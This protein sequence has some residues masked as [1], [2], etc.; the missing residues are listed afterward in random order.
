MAGATPAS[1]NQRYAR[2]RRGWNGSL[3]L[4]LSLSAG[5]LRADSETIYAEVTDELAFPL[6]AVRAVLL[7]LDR[8]DQW[9]PT[10]AEWRV[11]TRRHD[12]ARVYGRHRVP[13]PYRD[14]DY[15]VDY[16]WQTMAAGGFLLE[17]TARANCPASADSPAVEDGVVRIQMLQS[18]WTLVPAGEH[19][20][21]R[22]EI[23][24]LPPTRSPRWLEAAAQR[25]AGARLMRALQREVA[26]QIVKRQ[27]GD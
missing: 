16:R 10:L 21:V 6:A 24:T 17:A 13:W 18:R 11:L 2:S 3:V 26:E 23:T 20:T 5:T 27:Q 9:F 14:R 4:L 22:Y 19:T 8:F 25:R 7:D 1:S 12:G 15:V